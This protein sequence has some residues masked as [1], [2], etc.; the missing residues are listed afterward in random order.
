[1]QILRRAGRKCT[2]ELVD[3]LDGT[4]ACETVCFDFDGERYEI[5]LSPENAEDFRRALRPY[6]DR[7]EIAYLDKPAP[8]F[9]GNNDGLGGREG[10]LTGS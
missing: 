2:I 9:S 4:I 1:M 7:A 8:S 5:D 10:Y 6:I 3:D